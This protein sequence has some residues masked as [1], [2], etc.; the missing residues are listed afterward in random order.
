MTDVKTGQNGSDKPDVVFGQ[1]LKFWRGVHGL[2]QESLALSL[3]ASTRHISFLENGRASPSKAMVESIAEVLELGERDRCHLLLSAGY[4]PVA[5]PV[6]FYAPEYKWLRKA[7]MLSLKAQD[8]YPATL[9]D[10][11]GK[12]LMVN[13]GWVQFFQNACPDIELDSVINHYD[14]IFLNPSKQELMPVKENALVLM[15]MSL[16]QEAIL[17][18]DKR[19]Q[20]LVD[21]LSA[22]PQIPKDWQKRAAKLEP[23]ASFRIPVVIDGKEQSFFSVN[24]NVGEMGPTG[25]ISEPRLVINT[26]YP[27]D[28]SLVLEVSDALQHPLLPY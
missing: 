10:S 14:L 3:D 22:L 9:M 6:D 18:Q 7:M 25:Y 15:L 13:K 21:R 26:L 11:Y 28:E 23:M 1:L 16:Q 17:N 19:V 20:T 5:K 27:E 2:S 24:Q 12:L 8:P 4:K